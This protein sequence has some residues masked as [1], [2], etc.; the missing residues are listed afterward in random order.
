[1]PESISRRINAANLS[2]ADERQLRALLLSMFAD[3]QS[4][5]TQ[6]N[7]LRTDYNANATI[8]TDTTATA[9]TLNTTS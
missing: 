8:A 4:I 1:M 2:G 5:A 3:L 6:F 7:Q 9:I